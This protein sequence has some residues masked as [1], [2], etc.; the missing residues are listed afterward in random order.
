MAAKMM[1]ITNFLLRNLVFLG[2]TVKIGKIGARKATLLAR[3]ALWQGYVILEGLVPV[4]RVSQ[5]ML[6]KPKING[7]LFIHLHRFSNVSSPRYIMALKMLATYINVK[8]QE[9]VLVL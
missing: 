4:R 7:F 1:D 3:A 2:T 9:R 8:S 6:T 5:M